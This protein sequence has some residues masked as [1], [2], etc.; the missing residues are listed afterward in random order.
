MDILNTVLA[1]PL[2]Y[3]HFIIKDPIE[4]VKIRDDIR[5]M[6]SCYTILAHWYGF[7]TLD[8]VP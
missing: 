3:H 1:N 7:T 4:A 8:V 6:T 2:K 5:K